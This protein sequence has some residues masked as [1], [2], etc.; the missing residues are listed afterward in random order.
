MPVYFA[1]S[2]KFIRFMED[3]FCRNFICRFVF[4]YA[5]ISQHRPSIA[6]GPDCLPS[7]NPA[8]PREEVLANKD[9]LEIVHRLAGPLGVEALFVEPSCSDGVVLKRP[10]YSTAISVLPDGEEEEEGET[11]SGK[12]GTSIECAFSPARP[13]PPLPPSFSGV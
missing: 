6:R 5:V 10:T 7:S 3:D 11:G 4:C 13:R 8:F 2:P 9:V 12:S 1:A